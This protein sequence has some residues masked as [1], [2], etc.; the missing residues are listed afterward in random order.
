MRP[1]NNMENKAPSDT[2]KSSAS[3]YESAGS[4]FFRTTT[5]IQSGPGAS[6]ESRFVMI[7]LTILWAK[8]SFRLV[9]EGKT[10]KEMPEP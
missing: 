9:L 6:D 2:M 3:M 10:C 1:S 4:Q 8:C 7:C 5:G